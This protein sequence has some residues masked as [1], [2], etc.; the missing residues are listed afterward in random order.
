[1]S[2]VVS[3]PEVASPAPDCNRGNSARHFGAILGTSETSRESI[4]DLG[5]MRPCDSPHRLT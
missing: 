5:I 2:V 1:M 3:G 4:R